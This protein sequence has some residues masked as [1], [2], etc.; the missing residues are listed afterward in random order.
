M[1]VKNKSDGFTIPNLF[2]T[3]R[4]NSQKQKPAVKQVFIY[5]KKS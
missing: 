3:L 1:I 4:L 5:I 2:E